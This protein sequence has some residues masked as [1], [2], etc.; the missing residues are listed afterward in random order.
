MVVG[1]SPSEGVEEMDM[2]LNRVGNGYRGYNLG[3]LNGWRGDE[4]RA[5]KTGAFGVQ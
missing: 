2:L 5:G 1:Y 3:D 4:A